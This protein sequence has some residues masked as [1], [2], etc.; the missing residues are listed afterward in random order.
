MPPIAG[1]QELR[2][3]LHVTKG[4]STAESIAGA[5]IAPT[6]TRAAAPAV[7]GLAADDDDAATAGDGNSVFKVSATTVRAGNNVEIKIL[8]PRNGMRISLVD[9]Q[10]HEVAGVQ[11]NGQSDVVTLRAPW[12]AAPTRY[13]VEADFTDGF[14][15]ESIVEPITIVP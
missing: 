3:R 13:I 15:Q 5:V 1:G 8:A 4:R 6:V 10:S 9:L 2:V 14:G 12:V 7:A 11:T